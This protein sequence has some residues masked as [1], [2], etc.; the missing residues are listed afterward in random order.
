MAKALLTH[1]SIELMQVSV[2]A[3]NGSNMPLVD[4]LFMPT[5]APSGPALMCPLMPIK[6]QYFRAHSSP[7][8]YS[9]MTKIFISNKKA[10]TTIIFLLKP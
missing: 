2:P 4:Q 6:D 3:E 8:S 10:F 9:Q 7:T 5:H 1:V